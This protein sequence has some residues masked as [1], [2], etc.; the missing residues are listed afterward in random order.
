M[1]FWVLFLISLLPCG[2]IGIILSAIGFR[3]SSKNQNQYN[4]NDWNEWTIGG[5]NPVVLRDI[6]N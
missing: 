1:I 2:L 5:I 6:G 3:K 4:K